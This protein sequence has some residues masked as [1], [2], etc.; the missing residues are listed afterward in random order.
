MEW[1][2]PHSRVESTSARRDA[3]PFCKSFASVF[4]DAHS[5]A[6]WA[7]HTTW[8]CCA[9]DELAVR[10]RSRADT[11][12]SR[13]DECPDLRLRLSPR[14]AQEFVSDGQDEQR[15]RGRAY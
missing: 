14:A 10:V 7:L 9:N 2:I 6:M 11:C 8:R 15:Q 1:E 4:H 3:N 13:G 5:R 12:R